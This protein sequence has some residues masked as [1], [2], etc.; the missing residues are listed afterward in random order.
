MPSR[1]ILEI[2]VSPT[3]AGCL[4]ALVLADA[5]RR[6]RPEQ[7]LRVIDLADYQGPLPHGVIGTP[8]YRLGEDIISLGNPAW[9]DLRDRLD[10]PAG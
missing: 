3:C 1:R 8:T 5:V 4:T 9:E 7:P 6:Y 2:Y 10:S